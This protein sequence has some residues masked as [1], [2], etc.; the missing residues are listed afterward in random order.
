MRQKRKY[1]TPVATADLFVADNYCT[2]ACYYIA[3]DYGIAGGDKTHT[4]YAPKDLIIDGLSIPGDKGNNDFHTKRSNHTG[5]G[6]DT[7]QVVTTDSKGKV[8]GLSEVNVQDYKTLDATIVLQKGKTV[9]WTTQV[10]N[11][12]L[13][14]HKG[15]ITSKQAN[16]PNMS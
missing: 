8:L 5:C 12:R 1:E 13:W 16:H 3:C 7:S 14:S 10:G 4:S 15:T 2:S 9:Y 6:W 11:S